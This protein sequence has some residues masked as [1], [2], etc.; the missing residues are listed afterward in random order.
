MWA[1][2]VAYHIGEEQEVGKALQSGKQ[3]G[4]YPVESL[5]SARLHDQDDAVAVW[6]AVAGTAEI[7][8]LRHHALVTGLVEGVVII[9]AIEKRRGG[10][11]EGVGIFVGALF[12]LGS[13]VNVG[14][15]E[16]NDGEAS[17]EPKSTG[18]CRDNH[19]GRVVVGGKNPSTG[20]YGPYLDRMRHVTASQG[21]GG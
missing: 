1:R 21:R 18:I 6:E 10:I 14:G 3:L 13:Q 9:L 4:G 16:R 8:V 19:A 17:K 2:C 7:V 11:V 12:P 15:E 20:V 5:G